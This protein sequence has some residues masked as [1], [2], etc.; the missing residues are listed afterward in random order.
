MCERKCICIEESL[1]N[2]FPQKRQACCSRPE[3]AG[4][5]AEEDPTVAAP[6]EADCRACWDVETIDTDE[7][8]DEF[9]KD[10]LLCALTEI[11]FG[12][13]S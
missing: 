5:D 13:F 3:V 12:D 9:R 11:L 2:T 7:G 10:K 6:P 1:E 4:L 8:R